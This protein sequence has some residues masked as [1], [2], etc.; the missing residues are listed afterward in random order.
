MVGP[1]HTP[2][3]HA[4]Q[5]RHLIRRLAYFCVP[6]GM[7]AASASRGACG[8][9]HGGAHFLHA[10]ADAVCPET[11]GYLPGIAGGMCGGGSRDGG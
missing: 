6:S 9:V 11:V 7:A 8:G 2:S 1:A 3:R 10:L 5:P 4:L